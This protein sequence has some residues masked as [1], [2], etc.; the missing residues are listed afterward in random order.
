MKFKVFFLVCGIV[1]SSLATQA[2][3][4]PVKEIAIAISD[5]YIPSGFD[6]KSEAYVVVN[7]LFPNTCY[8]MASAKVEHKTGTEHVIQTIAKVKQAICIRVFVPFNQ[9]ISLGVLS[10]GS[11]TLRFV[12][13]DGTFFEKTLKVD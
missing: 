1:G 9:E 8:T 10:E 7:G 13:D 2:E 4:F 6:S 12:A 3:N 5:V 11:H